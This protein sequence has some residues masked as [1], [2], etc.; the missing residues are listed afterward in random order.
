MRQTFNS[1]LAFFVWAFIGLL[2]LFVFI[3]I[4][5]SKIFDW[6]DQFTYRIANLWG[7]VIVNINPQWNIKIAGAHHI[8]KNKGY[9]LVANHASLAD[10]VCLFC[11]G[12]H[13]KWVAKSSLFKIPV[14]GWTMTLLNYIPLSRG[15]HGSIRDSFNEAIDWLNKDVSVLIFPEGT[16]SRSGQLAE[17]KNG[18]FKLALLTKKPIVPIVISGTGAALTKGRATMAARV[19]GSIKVLAPIETQDYQ[20][21]DYEGLKTKVWNL[22]NQELSEKGVVGHV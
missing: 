5:I 3:A 7:Q 13:F 12:K 22:M 16:R 21:S 17:F 14:F 11:L 8:K 9:V 19:L 1:L 20:E 2:T 6:Q 10:I 4:A 15:R 18:A